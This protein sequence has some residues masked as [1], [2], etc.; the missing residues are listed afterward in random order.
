MEGSVW[1]ELLD[2]FRLEHGLTTPDDVYEFLD[3]DFRWVTMDY[4]GPERPDLHADGNYTFAV[5]HG[6][7][8]GA[9]TVAD[10]EAYDWADPEWWAP[11]DYGAARARWPEHA[12]V[13][14]PGWRPLFWGACEA[15]GM[16][17][18]LVNLVTRPHLFEAFVQRRHELYMERLRRG[19]TAARGHC[20][21]CWLA[22][23][24]AGQKAMFAAPEL[25]RRYIKPRLAEQV[26][27]VLAHGLH[28]LFHSC[29]AVRP[30]LPDM[31]DIGVS[32]MLVFQT[33]AADMAPE[34]IANKFGGRLVF[35]GG[36]DVQQLL[37]F[38]TPEQVRAEVRRNVR[39]F[40][41]CGGYVVA[42]S[43]NCLPTV[44]G[45]LLEVMCQEARTC[46]AGNEVWRNHA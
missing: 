35:Y 6:P 44:K 23:D 36:M 31:I 41:E 9:E 42:N 12:I 18:G 20:D 14:L 37:S 15:F 29:G 13:F 28:V 45:R 4:V 17:Q 24:F 11:G 3:V 5:A 43:H 40:A 26:E 16:E 32:G 34:S 21:I 7:L 33:N 38:G 30:V 25:W 27:L 39:A 10:V 19:L 22:D 2:Y 1:P 46:V 8:A